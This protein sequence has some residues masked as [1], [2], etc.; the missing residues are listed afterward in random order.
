LEVDEIRTS[1][2]R[3]ESVRS[4]ER[5]AAETVRV[6]FEE[7]QDRI[8]GMLLASSRDRDAAADITQETFLRLLAEVRRGRSPQ[9]TGAWLYRVALNLLVSRAR[10]AAGARRVLPRLL[11][12][13]WETD[14]PETVTLGHE[15]SQA[16]VN[17]L[18][19]LS[20]VERTAL[21]LAAQGVSGLEIAAY[22]GKPHGA[23]RSMLLRARR[24][25]RQSLAEPEDRR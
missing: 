1:P 15:A 4:D 14:T 11:R 2:V 19:R 10:R 20:L 21:V 24:K 16:A 8:Y 22:L 3:T 23:T 17:A 18:G 9:N 12:P 25:L 6:A 13:V 7:Y 5:A